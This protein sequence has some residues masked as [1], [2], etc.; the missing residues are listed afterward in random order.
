MTDSIDLAS[1]AVDLAQFAER[2]EVAGGGAL[3]QGL[4]RDSLQSIA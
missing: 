4:S 1:C 3:V 2:H